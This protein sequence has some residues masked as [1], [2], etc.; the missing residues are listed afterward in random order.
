[1]LT[2]VE[3]NQPATGGCLAGVVLSNGT[4]L[5]SISFVQ[6]SK[7]SISLSRCSLRISSG[8]LRLQNNVKGNSLDDRPVTL[9]PVRIVI[10]IPCS[11]FH[12]RIR[13]G[14]KTDF[15]KVQECWFFIGSKKYSVNLF[16]RRSMYFFYSC[17]YIFYTLANEMIGSKLQVS[18]TWE[19]DIVRSPMTLWDAC[20]FWSLKTKEGP[21]YVTMLFIRRIPIRFCNDISCN[22]ASATTLFANSYVSYNRED[23]RWRGK[24]L[25]LQLSAFS[26]GRKCTCRRR[27]FVRSLSR[28]R[29]G[30]CSNCRGIYNDSVKWVSNWPTISPDKT[31]TRAALRGDFSHTVDLSFTTNK[32]DFEQTSSINVWIDSTKE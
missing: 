8:W 15:F 16:L 22:I 7:S 4:K 2:L 17:T 18:R 23:D 13:F 25:Q 12:D 3:Q 27:P 11:D 1:M 32:R 31:P 20:S 14:T 30:T 26:R 6:P 9:S 28:R 29:R 24:L 5:R 19:N 10:M 21:T